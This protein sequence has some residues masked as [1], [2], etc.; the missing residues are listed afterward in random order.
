MTEKHVNSTERV[1][2]MKL[3]EIRQKVEQIIHDTGT[4]QFFSFLK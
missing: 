1:N 4:L 2:L 3:T